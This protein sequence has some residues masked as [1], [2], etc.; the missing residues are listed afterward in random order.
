MPRHVPLV[1]FV[2][3]LLSGCYSGPPEAA[4][5]LVSTSP[6]GAA[7]VVSMQGRPLT[8][9]APTP[10][11]ALVDPAAGGLAVSCRRSGFADANVPLPPYPATVRERRIDIALVPYLP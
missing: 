5:I 10:A 3:V 7:C 11:I 9:M 2:A 4:E 8:S 1:V 6:P